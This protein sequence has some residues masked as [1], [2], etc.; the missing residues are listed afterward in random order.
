MNIFIGPP[1]GVYGPSGNAEMQSPNRPK[2]IKTRLRVL[3]VRTTGILPRNA[4]FLTFKCRN[5]YPLAIARALFIVIL[6]V[7]QNHDYSH[8]SMIISCDHFIV[9]RVVQVVMELIMIL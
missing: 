6:E 4:N 3:F 1:Q 2:T 7:R 8:F 5:A 9:I